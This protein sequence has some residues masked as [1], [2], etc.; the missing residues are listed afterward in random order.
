MCPRVQLSRVLLHTPVPC[1]PG[2]TAT[3]T[4]ATACTTSGI[5]VTLKLSGSQFSALPDP[6]VAAV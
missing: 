5:T 1:A 3:A 2:C 4:A 6:P